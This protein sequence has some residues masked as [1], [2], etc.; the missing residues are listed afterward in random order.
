MRSLS[1]WLPLLCLVAYIVGVKAVPC[2]GSCSYSLDA[3]RKKALS[4][5]LALGGGG[6]PFASDKNTAT[7]CYAYS[8]GAHQGRAF[9]GYVKNPQLI[10]QDASPRGVALLQRNTTRK[11]EIVQNVHVSLAHNGQSALVRFTIG[12]RS[13]KFELKR[14]NVYSPGAAVSEY[15]DNGEEQ[16]VVRS[17]DLFQS[18]SEENWASA[19]I[20]GHVI[21]GVFEIDGA[22]VEVRPFLP[23]S[24][25]SEGDEWA[26]LLDFVDNTQN[27]HLAWHIHG[28][29]SLALPMFEEIPKGVVDKEPVGG[30]I[31]AKGRHHQHIMEVSKG[32]PDPLH[33]NMNGVTKWF[34][35]CYKGDTVQHTFKVGVIGDVVAYSHFGSKLTGMMAQIVAEASVVFEKQMNLKLE[36]GWSKVYKSNAGAPPYAVGCYGTPVIDKANKMLKGS[37]PMAGAV[38]LFTGCGDGSRFIGYAFMGTIC[39]N[40]GSNTGA[41]Q[42]RRAYNQPAWLN[43]AHELGHNFNGKH[44]FEHGMGRT[45]GIMDYLDGKLNGKYQFNTRYRKREICTKMS[46]VVG[47]CEGN[48][49]PSGLRE[50][51][52]A[53]APRPQPGPPP[54]P[55]PTP[56]PPAPNPGQFREVTSEDQ[57]TSVTAPKYRLACTYGCSSKP[58]T[59]PPPSDRRRRSRRPATPAPPS[60][61]ACKPGQ[62]QSRSLW[63]FDSADNSKMRCQ[64]KCKATLGCVAFDYTNISKVDACRGVLAGQTP[65]LGQPG[66]DNRHYCILKKPAKKE[67]TPKPSRRRSSRRR[68]RRRRGSANR[69]SLL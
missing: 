18:R 44:S 59:T 2:D 28:D 27:A 24:Q 66:A 58:P 60:P 10:E 43:F 40:D 30:I 33:A 15:G 32:E 17:V 23:E 68:R 52:P 48:F 26:S 13:H 19:S 11:P 53:P 12:E 69:Q 65:R 47:K 56:G 5:G 14:F 20:V 25:K 55:A 29:Q 6:Y 54:R 64:A 62:I 16:I 34:P 22:F 42:L 50:P 3:C 46:E 39:K 35:G 7:G 37:F 41:N 1:A 31:D 38:H 9:Y 45:G 8:S 61:S 4:L 63:H 21:S 36:V 51:R 67:P 49:D 57:L